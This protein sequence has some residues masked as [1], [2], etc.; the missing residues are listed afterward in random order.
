MGQNGRF[1][2]TWSKVWS[3][4]W[5]ITKSRKSFSIW[6]EF[7]SN[8]KRFFFFSL[9]EPNSKRFVWNPKVMWFALLPNDIG[10]SLQEKNFCSPFAQSDYL[11][12]SRESNALRSRTWSID[13]E[14]S[15][16]SSLFT[17]SNPLK[18]VKIEGRSL[19]TLEVGHQVKT[20]R[21][22]LRSSLRR[23]P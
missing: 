21:L 5:E 3:A 18:W 15:P 14:A 19:F 11:V 13:E 16:L 6:S 22:S 12:G 7:E 1:C 8:L 10:L 23:P 20:L 9:F 4:T 2:S 17:K